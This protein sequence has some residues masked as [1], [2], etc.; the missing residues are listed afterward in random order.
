MVQDLISKDQPTV[1]TY[2]MEL[3]LTLE[4]FSLQQM[5]KSLYFLF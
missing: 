3:H 1:N 2:L 5:A 4:F